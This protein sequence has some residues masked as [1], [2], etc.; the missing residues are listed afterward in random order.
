MEIEPYSS[1][2]SDNAKVVAVH[3]KLLEELKIRKDMV[4]NETGRKAEG[5]IT[6]FS[7]M[8]ALELRSIRNSGSRIMS[9]ILKLKSIPVK[10]FVINGVEREF[11]PYE[12]FKRLIIM[13]SVLN[14]KKDQPSL[15]IEI[16][17]IRGLKKNEI[18]YL[19]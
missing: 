3:P 1:W 16:T 13:A 9:E 18:K 17:K 5:G 14:R 10:K 11:V 15:K 7:E 6:A 4:E 12:L 8:A 19:Y 2:K